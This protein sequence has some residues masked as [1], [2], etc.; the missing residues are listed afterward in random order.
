MAKADLDGL[1]KHTLYLYEGDFAAVIAQHPGVPGAVVIRKIIRAYL[2]KL[3]PPIK[4]TDL[5]E[6]ELD[7]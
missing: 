3:S 7:V 5:T 6:T 2:H 4:P 1:Q